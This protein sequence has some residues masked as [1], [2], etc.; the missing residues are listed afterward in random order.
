MK[1]QKVIHSCDDKEFYSDFWPI[2][3]KIWKVKFNIEPVLLYFGSGNPSEEYGKVI[4]MKI[5]SDIPIN[6][7]CQLSRYWIP[8][9]EPE[10]V[11]M[12]S[13]IDMLPISKN[14]FIKTL[15]TIPDD[16]F[17]S[18]NSDPRET[19]PSILY[20]CCYNVAKGKT[21]TELLDI[22]PSWKKFMSS[23]FWKE[24]THTYTPDG[25]VNSCH[26]WGADET[27]SSGKINKFND[28]QRIIRQYRD[29]GRHRCH[30]IDRLDWNWLDEQVR[31]GELYDCH[32]IRPYKTHKES[33]DRLVKLI[34]ET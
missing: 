17:V 24:N 10:T 15:E 33:I 8:V 14:Y 5:L 9:T 31:N 11:W 22:N 19:Y 13:D 18:M 32:S 28:Q 30:R 3:S 2:V 25:L 29:C 34:L 12:T 20:S 27:W 7:Q 21:F 16:K 23:G 26:H 6:T 4:K 1:I